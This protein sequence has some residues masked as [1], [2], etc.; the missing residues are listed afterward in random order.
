[1]LSVGT[2]VRTNMA[3]DHP[4]GWESTIVGFATGFVFGNPGY[5]LDGS[6]LVYSEATLNTLEDTMAPTD[7][8]PIEEV[9]PFEVWDRLEGLKA[10][11]QDAMDAA[12]LVH[13][14]HLSVKYKNQYV[15]H[16]GELMDE[17]FY[18]SSI[19]ESA[20]DIIQERADEIDSDD[21]S[22]DEDDPWDDP[23][24][25]PYDDDADEDGYVYECDDD[26]D[27]GLEEQSE[28]IDMYPSSMF[29]F[30]FGSGL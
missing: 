25:A 24:Y 30:Y 28:L 9:L 8:A 21:D 11:C 4:V 16:E 15:W 10:R 6:D 5:L 13:D 3:G 23:D 2:R 22:D 12:Q 7:S 17:L 26:D 1:M 20:G 19:P 18:P 27:Y 29:N 14:T